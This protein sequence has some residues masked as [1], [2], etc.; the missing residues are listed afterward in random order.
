MKRAMMLMSIQHELGMSAGLELELKPMLK[1]FIETCIRRLNLCSGHVYLM[2]LAPHELPREADAAGRTMANHYLGIPSQQSSATQ[3]HPA[4]ASAIEAI[5][6]SPDTP[7]R[8]FSDAPQQFYHL[9]TIKAIGVLVL[10]R[11]NSQ[12]DPEIVKAMLPVIEQLGINCRAAYEHETML[13][14]T[15]KRQSTQKA[16]LA[17]ETR[18]R[19]L[20]DNLIDSIITTDSDGYIE[21]FNPAASALFGYSEREIIGSNINVITDCDL[22]RLSAGSN[23][24]SADGNGKR[25][26]AEGI[27]KG[28]RRFPIEISTKAMSIGTQQLYSIIIQ[29]IS[30]RKETEQILKTQ[31]RFA[32]AFTGIAELLVQEDSATEIMDGVST[33]VGEALETDR[34]LIY[35]IDFSDQY[36]VCLSEWINPDTHNVYST[37]ATYPLNMF[38]GGCEHIRQT[39][40]WLESHANLINP[41]LLEDQSGR[42]LHHQMGIKSLLWYPFQFS[43]TGYHLMVFHQVRHHRHWQHQEIDFLNAVVQHVNMALKKTILLNERDKALADL[44]LAATAF[45]A[46]EAMFV[47][48]NNA[49]IQRVNKAFSAITGYSE[50]EVLGKTPRILKSGKHDEHFYQTMWQTL[51][52]QGYW[53]GEV[54]NRRKNGEIYPEWQTITSVKNQQGE[55]THYISSFQDMTERKKTEAHIERLAYYDNLTGLPNRTLL[56]DRLKHELALSKRNKKYGAVL[57]LDLDRF[58]TINDSLGHSIGDALLRQVAQR[59][60]KQVR[61]ADTVARLGG[62]EFVIVLAELNND[63]EDAGFSAQIVAD[64]IRAALCLPY[65]L[66]DH[67]YQF[68]PSIGIAL[69]PENNETVDDVLKHADSAMYQAKSHGGNSI[70]FYMPDMQIAADERLALEKD[71]R[72]A[73]TNNELILHYQPQVDRQGQIIGAEALIRWQHPERGTICPNAFIP[74]AEE[75]GQVIEIGAWVMRE[76]FEQIK[77]WN[78]SG[79]CR[80]NP[81]F[82]INVSPRQFHQSDFV[83]QVTRLIAAAQISPSALK[84]EITENIVMKDVEDTTQKMEELRQLGVVFSID[85]FG[86]GYSSLAYLKQLPL[87]QIKID[88]SFVKDITNDPNDA[89]IVETIISMARHMKLDV[90]AEGVETSGQLSFL[91]QQ[92]CYSYQGYYFSKPLPAGEFEQLLREINDGEKSSLEPA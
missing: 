72:Q 42:M 7:H 60:Q 45:D 9:F 86:T 91:K 61:G 46:Q 55:I 26:E 18:F 30:E 52:Q 22:P 27:R 49:T 71:L 2:T 14:E 83:Q 81:S 67:E 57:F 41:H 70:R 63:T 62:D 69:F 15:Q 58:K 6:L 4:L 3:H 84:L 35:D 82:A 34:A 13:Y 8:L 76:A 85:D 21:S 79:L 43:P 51:E 53:R 16:L 66:H 75:T 54:W 78:T 36:V 29:D 23:D 80:L 92:G 64:K 74:M 25:T 12:L 50:Q 47:T 59:I 17:S 33:I 10:E 39:K 24:T 31:L 87:S 48:D 5:Y 11:K 40:H 65:H 56:L 28:G 89:T 68:T 90:L 44:R 1:K 32:K 73:I 38:R 20:L 19:T 77:A 88:R 37:K